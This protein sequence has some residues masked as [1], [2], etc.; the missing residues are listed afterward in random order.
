MLLL[1]RLQKVLQSTKA[2]SESSAIHFVY[3]FLLHWLWILQS[4]TRSCILERQEQICNSHN[5]VPFKEIF[6]KVKLMLENAN[7]AFSY[8]GSLKIQ[9]TQHK[10]WKKLILQYCKLLL[11]LAHQYD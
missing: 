1:L 7:P 4:T 6:M 9:A 5:L 11:C 2:S 8:Q 10:T 3:H